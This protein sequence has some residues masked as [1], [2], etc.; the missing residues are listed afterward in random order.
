MTP[1]QI[2]ALRKRLQLSANEFAEKLGFTGKNKALTV[3]RWENGERKPSN[4]TVLL[5]KQL[6]NS[7]E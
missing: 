7:Q 6:A 5:I 1:N 4:Q 2:K 3:Y